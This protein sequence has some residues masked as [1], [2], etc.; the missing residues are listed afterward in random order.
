[1]L[2][3]SDELCHL[4]LS[5]VLLRRASGWVG[6]WQQPTHQ[7]TVSDPSIVWAVSVQPIYSSKLAGDENQ[8]K[9]WCNTECR[10]SAEHKSHQ[11]EVLSLLLRAALHS[12]I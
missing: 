2:I 8:V 11:K 12:V 4:I 6:I 10:Y 1:M 7:R 5:H 9:R 3:S